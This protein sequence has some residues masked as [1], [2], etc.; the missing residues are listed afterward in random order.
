MGGGVPAATAAVAGAVARET[1]VSRKTV[2]SSQPG[3]DRMDVPCVWALGLGAPCGPLGCSGAAAAEARTTADY[4]H[5]RDV[6]RHQGVAF[7]P[8]RD[9][10][11]DLSALAN[12]LGD[13]SGEEQ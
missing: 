2:T 1:G 12:W 11:C 5:R 4:R 9:L 13:A 7:A 8:R 10:W 3:D 6:C